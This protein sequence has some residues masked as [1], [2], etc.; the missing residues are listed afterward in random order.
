M[1]RF[2]QGQLIHWIEDID[3]GGPQVGDNKCTKIEVIFE[4]GQMAGVPWANAYYETGRIVKYNLANVRAV[5]MLKEKD[6][7][8]D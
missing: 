6:N 1:K 7:E 3:G 5:Q 8:V 2:E 4:N